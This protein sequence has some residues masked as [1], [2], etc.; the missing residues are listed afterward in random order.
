MSLKLKSFLVD[1]ALNPD[2][3]RRYSEDPQGIVDQAGLTADEQA[4][5]LSGDSVRL[6][7]ALGK[8][9]N[10]CMSQAAVQKTAP[11]GSL[12]RLPDGSLLELNEDTEV[13]ACDLNPPD[14]SGQPPSIPENV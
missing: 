1:L 2:L 7:T 14:G 8:P 6:R 11:K 5:F 9:D 4:A 10:D 3:M 12:V 13:M